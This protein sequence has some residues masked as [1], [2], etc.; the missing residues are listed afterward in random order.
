M[1][2]VLGL[3][4]LFVEKLGPL[5]DQELE[6]AG[7]DHHHFHQ[8]VHNKRLPADRPNGHDNKKSEIISDARSLCAQ[9]TDDCCAYIVLKKKKNN[10]VTVYLITYIPSLILRRRSRMVGKSGRC[11]GDSAQ[12]SS[13]QERMYSGQPIPMSGC[14]KMQ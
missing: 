5:G 4:F 1:E 9:Y 7:I 12:Q 6:I 11:S 2:E 3:L 8:L 10:W 14:T 13:M